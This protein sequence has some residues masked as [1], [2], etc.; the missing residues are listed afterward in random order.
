MIEADGHLFVREPRQRM[1][2]RAL[3]G[4]D[5]QVVEVRLRNISAM[6]ALVECSAPVTPGGSVTIDIIG[7]GPVGGTICWAH[8][9]RFGV[10]FKE[11]LDLGR[12]AAKA[13][14]YPAFAQPA[15]RPV[16]TGAR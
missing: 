12:L 2:R 14:S 3:M 13:V 8:R 4:I 7:F 16:S 5:G 1:R 9:E 10:S 11:E 15:P 6:G